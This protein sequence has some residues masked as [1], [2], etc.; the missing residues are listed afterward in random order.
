[1]AARKRVSSS[2]ASSVVRYMTPIKKNVTVDASAMAGLQERAETEA[3][4]L[5]SA[6]LII[7]DDYPIHA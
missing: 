6:D 5:L 1:M 3:A 7:I 4:G 2:R